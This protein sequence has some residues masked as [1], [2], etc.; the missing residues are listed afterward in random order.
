[1]EADEVSIEN[2]G[3]ILEYFGPISDKNT[4]TP[5]LDRVRNVLSQTWFHGDLDTREAER[6]LG[7]RSIGTYLVRF[8]TSA[9]GGFTISKVSSKN[10]THQRILHTSQGFSIGNNKFA[11]LEDLINSSRV[12]LHLDQSCPGSK[13][14]QLF[15][16]TNNVDGYIQNYNK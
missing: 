14:S 13:F 7:G 5:I 8:S 9:P 12:D 10:I 3:S 15:E 2:F 4:T 11:T 1:M 16:S 6:L